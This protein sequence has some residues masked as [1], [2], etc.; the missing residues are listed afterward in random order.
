MAV[1]I[2]WLEALQFQNAQPGFSTISLPARASSGAV[3]DGY[4]RRHRDVIDCCCP[5]GSYDTCRAGAA[6]TI[7]S[8][9]NS[10]QSTSGSFLPLPAG[11]FSL[12]PSEYGYQSLRLW[13]RASVCRV[14]RP[15]FCT[16]RAYMSST[17]GKLGA[18]DP[19]HYRTQ[20]VLRT[21]S[22][23]FVSNIFVFRRL[24]AS[25][26]KMTNAFRRTMFR[27]SRLER[28][29]CGYLLGDVRQRTSVDF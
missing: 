12:P 7:L 18:A 9:A 14:L 24:A 20:Q 26:V 5:A 13:V 23:C 6:G 17:A 4:T 29:L 16:S 10:S 25:C 15:S 8:A 2:G 11:F 21:C 27:F 22:T 3:G 28:R 19:C 1:G